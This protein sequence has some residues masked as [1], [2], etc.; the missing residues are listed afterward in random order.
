MSL[1]A[2]RR[3][4]VREHPVDH[5][6]QISDVNKAVAVQVTTRHIARVDLQFGHGDGY[7]LIYCPTFV[8]GCA[9]DQTEF[10]KII[11]SRHPGEGPGVVSREKWF[12]VVS[13]TIE[14]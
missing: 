8:V 10:A 7:R 13:G 9:Q 4:T 3:R 14:G 5:E 2:K 11:K 1:F 6:Y 12:I